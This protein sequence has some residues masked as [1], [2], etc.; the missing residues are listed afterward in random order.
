M[1]MF[2]CHILSVLTSIINIECYSKLAM[3]GKLWH[4]RLDHLDIEVVKNILS[5]SNL[6]TQSTSLSKVCKVC[7]MGK[8]HRLS[9]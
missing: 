1:V 7:E 8:S 4:Y 2:L 3:N 5:R 9:M 6:A